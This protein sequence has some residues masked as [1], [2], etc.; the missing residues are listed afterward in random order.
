MVSAIYAKVHI[1]PDGLIWS[2]KRDWEKF[3]DRVDN[4]L[5]VLVKEEEKRKR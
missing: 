1:D 2:A 4:H 5:E 3:K